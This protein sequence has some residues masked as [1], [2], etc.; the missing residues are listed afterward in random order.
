MTQSDTMRPWLPRAIKLLSTGPWFAS[1]LHLES[2][3]ADAMRDD[4]RDAIGYDLDR[5]G[6]ATISISGPIY[7]GQPGGH[8]EIAA[9]LDRATTDGARVVLLHVNS[10]GGTVNGTDELARKVKGISDSGVAV[11]SYSDGI[12]ASAA[13]YITAGAD[14]RGGAGSAVFGSIGTMLTAMSIHGMLQRAGIDVRTFTSGALKAAF[15]PLSKMTDA[16]AEMLQGYT[17]ARGEEFRSFMSEHRPKMDVNL[18]DGRVFTGS[19]A[20]ANGLIDFLSPSL[21]AFKALLQPA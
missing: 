6:I 10:P 2:F 5:S 7:S 14:M 1:H 18:M 21:S 12:Q 3:M 11:A 4:E 20:A 9:A 19:Q 8:G 13:E 17:D 16:Q 15:S